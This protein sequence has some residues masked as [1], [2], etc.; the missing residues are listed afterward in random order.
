MNRD[1]NQ[2]NKKS[3]KSHRSNSR[4]TVKA[5]FKTRS[6]KVLIEQAQQYNAKESDG[7][8]SKKGKPNNS[9]SS[10]STDSI[11][12]VKTLNLMDV[13]T[14]SS[15]ENDHSSNTSENIDSQ[16]NLSLTHFSVKGP[17]VKRKFSDILELEESSSPL[18]MKEASNIQIV[19]KDDIELC[20]IEEII[21]MTSKQ[22]KIILQK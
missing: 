16:F 14:S 6:H 19:T 2:K 8:S 17:K 22:D 7:G 18:G 11:H 5:H 21:P 1:H 20:S 3:K 4:S 9:F 12:E 10:L 15:S 13:S